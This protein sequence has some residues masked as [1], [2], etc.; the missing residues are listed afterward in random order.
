LSPYVLVET[1]FTNYAEIAQQY[2]LRWMTM[3]FVISNNGIPYWGF[4]WRAD[5]TD[6][7]DKVLQQIKAM[8]KVNVDAIGSFGGAAGDELAT[9]IQSESALLDAYQSVISGYNFKFI[10]FDIEGANLADTVTNQRRNRVLAHLQRNNSDV[11]LSFT[12]P[13]LPT[14]LTEIGL[15]LLRDAKSVGVRIDAVNIMA[16]DYG[17]GGIDM[18]EAAIQAIQNTQAQLRQLNLKSCIG[19]IPMI[20]VNDVEGEVFRQN[21]ARRLVAFTNN[22]D[23]GVC[24][25]SYWSLDRDNTRDTRISQRPFEFTKI[26]AGG[27]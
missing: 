8:R 19:V 4:S 23:N 14:G 21:D 24:I 6:P 12:L 11:L 27:H 13:V 10:D 1:Y 20:G 25:T 15:N 18:G 17:P 5:G 7:D 9:V 16:M 3:A 2:S 26:F 22:T